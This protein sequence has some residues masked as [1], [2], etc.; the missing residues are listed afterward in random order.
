MSLKTVTTLLLLAAILAV[1]LSGV[2]GE[3]YGRRRSSKYR[4]YRRNSGSYMY[5]KYGNYN[6]YGRGNN[7]KYGGGSMLRRFYQRNAAYD[8]DHHYDNGYNSG[9]RYYKNGYD[10]HIDDHRRPLL[11]Y[12]TGYQTYPM[13]SRGIAVYDNMGGYPNY[14]KVGGVRYTGEYPY[15]RNDGGR[16]KNGVIYSSG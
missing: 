1:S 8:H 7:G 13:Q 3:G 11:K 5:N 6:R 10:N 4:N 14:D 9:G 12:A 16:Y 2:D 15:D